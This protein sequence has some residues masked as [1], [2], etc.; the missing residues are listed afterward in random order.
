MGRVCGV[1]FLLSVGFVGSS[2]LFSI[3]P[4]SGW[5]FRFPKSP[6]VF[7][8]FDLEICQGFG[9]I[10]SLEMPSVAGFDHLGVDV[11]VASINL[12][13]KAFKIVFLL[14]GHPNIRIKQQLFQELVLIVIFWDH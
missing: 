9:L 14:P 5:G 2:I 6:F 7:F 1:L 4:R 12:G 10:V 13:Q 8:G 11:L 3:I